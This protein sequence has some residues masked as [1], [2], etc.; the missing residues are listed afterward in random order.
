MGRLTA[1]I[2]HELYS[3]NKHTG[4]ETETGQAA[5]DEHEV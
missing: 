4:R 5:A 1:C 3:L 2:K